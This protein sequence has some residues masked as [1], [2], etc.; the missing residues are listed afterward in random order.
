MSDKA[1]SLVR[2]ALI[3][4]RS[5]GFWGAPLRSQ[6]IAFLKTKNP[7]IPKYNEETYNNYLFSWIEEF[8][9][10][11]EEFKKLN[12]R[13]EKDR[14]Q[15][16]K[17]SK[18]TEQLQR[19]AKD[20]EANFAEKP[21][22][23]YAAGG[24]TGNPTLVYA[25]KSEAVYEAWFAEKLTKHFPEKLDLELIEEG[26]KNSIE[27]MLREKHPDYQNLEELIATI[28]TFSRVIYRV[29]LNTDDGNVEFSTDQPRVYGPS[30]E[31]AKSLKPENR[32]VSF[33]NTALEKVG[34]SE[35]KKEGKIASELNKNDLITM[36]S[37]KKI[38]IN[39]GDNSIILPFQMDRKSIGVGPI[40][41]NRNR[42]E[43]VARA[44]VA[45]KLNDFFQEKSTLKGFTKANPGLDIN[46][47][48][49]QQSLNSDNQVEAYGAGFFIG[50]LNEVGKI[51]VASV[52][53]NTAL[54]SY[55]ISYAKGGTESERIRSQVDSIFS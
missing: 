28:S 10:K 31:D 12:F 23:M 2:S 6:Y 25:K 52:H 37:I 51:E 55:R 5:F 36:D 24:K 20:L 45:K 14:E 43:D 32:L 49:I 1:K 50:V 44:T 46:Q 29:I 3:D 42:I 39:E 41:D 27:E 26:L 34:V 7:A 15:F 4:N 19:V 33:M 13:A 47:G 48:H 30:N 35:D 11:L 21:Y 9:P 54:H 38:A 17:R 53:V 22:D 8:D 40:E 18:L 16:T